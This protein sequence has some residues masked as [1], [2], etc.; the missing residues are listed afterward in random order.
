MYCFWQWNT[1]ALCIGDSMS[2]HQEKWKVILWVCFAIIWKYMVIQPFL[3]CFNYFW[4]F[5]GNFGKNSLFQ[6]SM[7]KKFILS[8][9]SVH[10]WPNLSHMLN[11]SQNSISICILFNIWPLLF[12]I[13]AIL[14]IFTILAVTTAPQSETASHPM[15]H[16][17]WV[18]SSIWFFWVVLP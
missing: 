5:L 10:M 3:A 16:Q 4:P 17:I 8:A 6:M 1:A 11:I 13:V 15:S 7:L 9:I 2:N 14:T 12:A 18:V